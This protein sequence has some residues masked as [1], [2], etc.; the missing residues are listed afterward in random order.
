MM[1]IRCIASIV[2]AACLAVNAL[3][4]PFAELNGGVSGSATA[5]AEKYIR[6][7]LYLGLSRKGG[8]DVN[9]AEFRIF[10]DEFVTPRFPSGFTVFDARGQW[11]E[12]DGTITKE[13]TKVLILIYRRN[14]RR[15]ANEK[16]EE[17]RNEYKKRFS[18]QSVLRSDI[19]KGVRVDF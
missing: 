5:F 13:G 12:N 9:E 19:T 10:I 3:G 16:I 17:I 7:E 11:R 8:P 6:T 4:L 1:S 2:L 14:E 18:Q 15:P